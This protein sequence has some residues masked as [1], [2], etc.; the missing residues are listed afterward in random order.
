ML[1]ASKNPQGNVGELKNSRGFLGQGSK[2][3]GSGSCFRGVNLIDENERFYDTLLPKPDVA[4][5]VDGSP[6]VQYN[7]FRAGGAPRTNNPTYLIGHTVGGASILNNAD[8][9]Y[10]FPFEPKYAKVPRVLDPLVGVTISQDLQGNTIPPRLVS[11]RAA[12]YYNGV[13]LAYGSTLGGVRETDEGAGVTDLLPRHEFSIVLF[14]VGSNVSG[15]VGG[16]YV[17][18]T[19]LASLINPVPRGWKYG[20]KS[21]VPEHSKIVMR[22]D[23]YGQYR[24]MMEQR[25]DTKFYDLGNPIPGA[26]ERR[27]PPGVGSAAIQVRFKKVI[28]NAQG[29]KR[30]PTTAN[31]TTQCSNM[32]MEATS[33]LPFFDGKARNR[34]TYATLDS[35]SILDITELLDSA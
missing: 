11:G 34:F 20:L 12:V 35:Q 33:S 16:T 26:G 31:E 3:A 15:T 2:V 1:S 28:N 30:V 25:N 10:S 6:P 17:E 14:G 27:R 13:E 29:L 7:A 32:S 4:F 5:N 23:T 22:R 9:N 18:D 8:W 24:D 21:A 19:S